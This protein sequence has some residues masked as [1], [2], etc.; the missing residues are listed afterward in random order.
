MRVFNTDQCRSMWVICLGVQCF[1]IEGY[2]YCAQTLIDAFHSLL[3]RNY[4][5]YLT[6]LIGSDRLV[7]LGSREFTDCM[8]F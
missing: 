1:P 6:I 7:F 5:D 3:R 4:S 2:P 8:L